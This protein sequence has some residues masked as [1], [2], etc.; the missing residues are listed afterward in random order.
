MLA[1]AWCRSVGSTWTLELREV[2]DDPDLAPAAGP[3][4]DWIS[5]GVPTTFRAPGDDLAADLLAE[6]GL[7]FYP[8]PHHEPVTRSRGTIGYARRSR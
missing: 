1:A 3:P 5:S 6:R 7:S 2:D 8:R 4:V